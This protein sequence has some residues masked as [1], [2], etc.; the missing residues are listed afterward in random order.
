MEWQ[1]HT[2]SDV[3]SAF[4]GITAPPRELYDEIHRRGWTVQKV[5]TKDHAFQAIGKNPHGEKIEAVG[6]S[7]ATA[8]GNLLHKIMRREYIRRNGAWSSSFEDQLQEIAQAYAEAPAYDAKA[9]AAWIELARDCQ[10]RAQVLQGQLH[11]EIVDD[12]HPYKTADEMRKDVRDKQHI[13]VTRAYPQHPVWSLDQMVA[14]RLVHDVLGH[15]ASGGDWG[16]HGENQACAAHFPLLN[17]EAQKALFTEALG[18]SAFMAVYG[19]LGPQKIAFL[20]DLI[21]KVQEKENKPGHQGVHPSQ[22]LAPA[23]VPD[24]S[25]E[26]APKKEA[27]SVPSRDS[28]EGNLADPNHR[29]QSGI[30]PLP[31]NAFL[32]QSDPQTGRD[33]LDVQNLSQMAY[34]V[35][36]D[37]ASMPESMQRQSVANAFRAALLAP[38]KS[39]MHNAQH[40]QHVMGIPADVSDPM[41]YWDALEEQRRQHNLNKGLPEPGLPFEQELGQFRR[42]VKALNPRMDDGEV[43]ERSRRE[44]LHM[45]QEEEERI[46]AEDADEKLPASQI[47][48]LA[49][50]N[51]Q[52]RLKALTKPRS[53][54]KTDFGNHSLFR[55]AANIG[56]YGSYLA[57]H[58]RPIAGVSKH[59]DELTNA[60][61]EDLHQHKG[62]GHH[63][64][65]N[66]LNAQIPGVTPK[67]A[68]LAWMH[69]NPYGSQLG[70][71]DPHVMETLGH[72]YSDL[73][74]R[75]YFKHERELAAGRDAA[76]YGHVPLGQ[77]SWGMR[78]Y[79]T[80]GPGF[81]QDF[82]PMRVLHPT[83]WEGVDWQNREV[84]D[85]GWADPYWW[86]STKPARDATATDWD[87]TIAV[88]HPA[89]EV[90]FQKVAVTLYSPSYDYN[91][92]SDVGAPGE[93]H[94]QLLKM[95]LG[96]NSVHD[97]WGLEGLTTQK[98][99]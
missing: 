15:C 36:P 4:L 71:L 12:P 53:D 21:A 31:D 54:D 6:N 85:A 75:D 78:D 93:T 35:S 25:A 20:D 22:S 64:R 95:N 5:K 38:R 18:Q 73:N 41:V 33:P 48:M 98:V 70:V 59:I 60:A 66:A 77:F 62:H 32:W 34:Q 23:A 11:V 3:T 61:L 37:L 74:D 65:A 97:I 63:F 50:Q 24:L 1:E 88:N 13:F 47:E 17:E 79:K 51:L 9:A 57:S 39:A 99:R 7:E 40:Y 72:Q 69:L 43:Y 82:S 56:P 76:G 91:G 55:E 46:L 29:W 45:L 28:R 14:Y 83:P 84:G 68:S 2:G 92:E 96:L 81:H 42:W 44:L 10:S 26:T 67:V 80:G 27:A 90:P 30:D 58:V 8:V 52:K 89:G 49:H 87:R 19:Q 94:M 86:N 16:W